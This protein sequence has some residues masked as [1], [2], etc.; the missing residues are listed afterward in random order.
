VDGFRNNLPTSALIF[1]SGI[2]LSD[3]RL[4]GKENVGKENSGQRVGGEFLKSST[5]HSVSWE[6]QGSRQAH[7]FSAKN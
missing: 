7:L 1:L 6:K 4:A 2:F 5:S 3:H